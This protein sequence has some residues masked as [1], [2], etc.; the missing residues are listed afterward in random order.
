MTLVITHAFNSTVAED[1]SSGLPGGPVGPNEWNAN[2]TLTGL[3]S[4]AQGG[5]NSNSLGSS[6]QILFNSSGAVNGMS[7]TSWDN[8]NLALAI[9][10]ATVTTS[11]P[12]L[13]LSQTW[14]AGGV[15]F[16]GLKLNVVPTASATASKVLDVQLNGASELAVGNS[17]GLLVGG[18][19]ENAGFAGFAHILV[20]TGGSIFDGGSGI[21]KIGTISGSNWL[22]IDGTNNIVY[23]VDTSGHRAVVWSPTANSNTGIWS[24]NASNGVG[25]TSSATDAG[26][27]APDTSIYRA[28]SK[29]IQIGDGAADA[30]GWL[31]WG[32]Q[33][34]VTSDF[35]ITSSTVLTNVTGLSVNVAAGRTYY[36]EAELYVTD[37]AAGGVQAAIAGTA[38]ATAIQYTGYTIADNAIKAKTNATALAT[39]VGSTLTTETSGIIVRITGTI[40]VNAA[41]SLTVQM[42]QNTSNGTATTAKRGSY[43]IV[44]DMP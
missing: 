29:V 43:L 3:A 30:N 5:T 28:A 11:N 37:A 20:G 44:H 16:T 39:A 1:P 7:G 13:S 21:L 31:N 22:N 10:G 24:F 32:G 15:S 17:G 19:A 4:V 23:Y 6:G 42:A 14:N 26:F 41:G 38:T 33:A 36:F 34:R 40:T 2:H 9:T 8:T 18:A 12:I 35:P 25:W 27:P